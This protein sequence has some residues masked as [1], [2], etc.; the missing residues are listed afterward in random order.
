M[1]VEEQ[2]AVI[3]I[4]RIGFFEFVPPLFKQLRIVLKYRSVIVVFEIFNLCAVDVILAVV[5]ERPDKSD[6]S[7]RILLRVEL[8]TAHP[9]WMIFDGVLTIRTIFEQN[10]KPPV[11]VV[12]DE[13]LILP[14]QHRPVC[15]STSAAEQVNKDFC[16]W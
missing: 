12:H 7:V 4:S 8:F 14:C 16:V 13:P 6:I 1:S 10:R 2:I 15:H 5:T 9:F 11:N 3:R